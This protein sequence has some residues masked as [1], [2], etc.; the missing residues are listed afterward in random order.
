V[1]RKRSLSKQDVRAVQHSLNHFFAKYLDGG[2][3]PA[4]VD[5]ELG[6]ET[7][8]RIVL[9]KFY[10]GY[11][12][13]QRHD[14]SIKSRFVRRLRHPHSAAFSPPHML[15]V[16]FARR[17][18]YRLERK[19]AL[20]K[21]HGPAAVVRLA[22][23][24]AALHIVEHPA[25]SNSGPYISGWQ[26]EWGFGA[27]AW[28][29]IYAGHLARACGA[30]GLTSRVASVAA[31]EDDAKA[32]RNGFTGWH[33]SGI[34]GDFAVLFGRGI[35]VE[36][37]IGHYAGGY[38]TCGG[39]TGPEGGGGSQSNGGG[40]FIRYRPYSVVRGCARPNYG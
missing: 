6:P 37:I 3:R 14:G 17:R 19:K 31:I 39:N 40:V 16:A 36:T 2:Y 7:K 24:Y 30:K 21:K 10:L 34:V 32:H 15:A 27:V 1:A 4:A 22:R 25:G 28:C 5:G 18:K 38:I 33:G 11:G 20:A 23:H 12:R 9:A 35:H 8:G 26:R 29:G 13:K